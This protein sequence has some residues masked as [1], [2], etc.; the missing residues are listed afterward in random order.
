MN[1]TKIEYLD[2]TWNPIVG[3]SGTNCA[4]A[5]ACWA[6][7]QAKRQKPKEDKNGNERGCQECYDFKPHLHVS[8]LI[9]PFEVLTPSRIGVCFM[10]DL[11]D[12]KVKTEWQKKIFETISLSPMH[13]FIVLTKQPQN[14]PEDWRFPSNVWLGV[15]VNK[16][17]DLLRIAELRRRSAA[18]KFVSFEP[19]FEDVVDEFFDELVNVTC[20]SLDLSGIDWVIIGAQRRP[21]VQPKKEWVEKLIHAADH[22]G[23]K[24]FMKNNLGC[25]VEL[26]Y[27]LNRGFEEIPG[28]KP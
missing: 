20:I 13:T 11:F 22:A 5:G 25:R 21:D 14:I 15:S 16:I 1:R 27:A 7:G 28:A 4:V 8:R 26:E 18:V 3:C 24:I 2:Y 19:L 17:S 23:C 12:D 9:Q 10:G 6:K